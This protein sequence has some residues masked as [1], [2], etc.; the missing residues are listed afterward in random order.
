MHLSCFEGICSFWFLCIVRRFKISDEAGLGCSWLSVGWIA[1]D[2][3][4]AGLSHPS[5][6]LEMKSLK[7]MKSI[8]LLSL[9]V[10]W[11]L[12]I[13]RRQPCIWRY[14]CSSYLWRLKNIK[15]AWEA[16]WSNVWLKSGPLVSSRLVGV[17]SGKGLKLGIVKLMWSSVGYGIRILVVPL[18]TH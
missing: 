4:C 3:S 1:Y 2:M 5:F 11:E 9:R 7:E 10:L 18:Q 8:K 12:M 17:F 13:R 6:L 16:W 15:L 14:H